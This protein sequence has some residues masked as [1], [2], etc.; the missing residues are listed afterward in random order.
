MFPPG[1]PLTTICCAINIWRAVCLCSQ[2]KQR[3]IEAF[4]GFIAVA[5]GMNIWVNGGLHVVQW[6][7]SGE[8]QWEYLAQDSYRTSAIYSILLACN[9]FNLLP[10]ETLLQSPHD[11]LTIQSVIYITPAEPIIIMPSTA[12]I[13][14]EHISQRDPTWWIFL[15]KWPFSQKHLGISV[16]LRWQ[17]L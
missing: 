4:R 7:V 1:T 3:F 15:L 16:L 9:N 2:S 11:G 5:Q 13:Y 14:H 8:S 17:H 6:I 12:T 10:S